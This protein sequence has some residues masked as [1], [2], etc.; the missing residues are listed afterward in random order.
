MWV[1]NET[2]MV[3]PVAEVVALAAERGAPVHTDAAQ[4][5]GKVP[6]DVRDVP[7]DLLSATG[8]KIYGPKGTGILYVREGTPLEPLLHGGGQERRVRPGTEDVAGAVGFATALRLAVAELATETARLSALRERLAAALVEAVP[9]ARINAAEAPRAPH[10]LSVG[11]AGISDGGA[12]LMALDINGVAASGGSACLSGAAKASHVMRALYGPHDTH[13]TVR[14]SL[15]RS[16]SADDVDRAA[17][18][19]AT[20]VRRMREAA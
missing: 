19:T 7:V 18:V 17:R 4:A 3:L 1:N 5:I 9:G 16:T 6:V 10:V 14:F 8:H 11:I 15:G 12:L 13:A 2:G 20:V